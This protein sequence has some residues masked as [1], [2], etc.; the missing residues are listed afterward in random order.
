MLKRELIRGRSRKSLY[1]IELN[2][3]WVSYEYPYRNSAGHAG[4]WA[5]KSEASA[6]SIL[7]QEVKKK[8]A[9]G[10]VETEKSLSRR[11]FHLISGKSKKFW[12]VELDRP[13]M[14]VQ[15]GRIDTY[16][17]CRG[18]KKTKTFGDQ[19][20]ALAKY[21]EAIEEKVRKGYVEVHM[22]KTPYSKT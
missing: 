21:H 10:Y 2:G 22:R 7:K 8:L 6:M 13:S 11:T 4:G 9:Q 16:G 18:Q 17:R 19:E 12:A 15:F 3:Y 14:T 1:V 5:C 20:T